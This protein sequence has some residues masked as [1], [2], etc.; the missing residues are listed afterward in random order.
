MYKLICIFVELIYIEKLS[1]IQEHSQRITRNTLILYFRMI[2]TMLVSLYTS[3]VVLNTLG[4]EDFGIYNVVGGVVAMLSFINGSLSAA[5]SRYI[6]YELAIGTP[7]SLRKTFSCVMTIHIFIALLIAILGETVGSWFLLHELKI[8]ENRLN[9]AIW[10]FQCSILSTMLSIISVPYNATIIAHEKM[11]VYAYISIMD[12]MLKLGIVYLL[13][14]LPFDKLKIYALLILAIQIFDVFVYR[15]YTSTRFKACKFK[16]TWDQSLF[17]DIF[18]FVGWTINGNLAVIGYTQGLNILL[19]LFF[20]PAINAARGIAVQ[21]Q[22]VIQNF[23]NNFQVAL[24]PQ[25]TKSYAQSDFE[26]MHKL[27]IISSKFSFLLLL[28]LS[29][30][31]IFEAQTILKLNIVPEYTVIFLRLILCSSMLTALANPLIISVHAT[32]KLKTFQLVEG[33]MLLTIVP[34][35]YLLLKFCNVPPEAVFIVHIGIEICTQFARMKIVL[36]MIN[37]KIHDYIKNVLFPITKVLILSPIIPFIIYICMPN[38]WYSFIMVCFTSAFSVL[39]V[40]YYIGCQKHER[41]FIKQKIY[42]IIMKL[43]L[44]K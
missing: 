37:M 9:S 11:N 44:K 23:C 38:N 34:I 39:I 17:K 31:I 21:V 25:L 35:S 40:T 7:E 14:I 18:I 24:N 15:W 32:G 20:G 8:P 19:N 29:M 2:F 28:L 22:T 42:T 16:F 10:V 3:R 13:V 4:V 36:P 12:V 5:S 33:S 1:M 6:T 26:Y 27:L 41:I 30:P 43:K